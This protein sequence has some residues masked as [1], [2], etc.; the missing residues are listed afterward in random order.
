[1]GNLNPD[2]RHSDL[3]CWVEGNKCSHFVV[4]FTGKTQNI[5]F[6][7]IRSMGKGC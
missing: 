3:L 2:E 6:R 1:M 5:L 7:K 4:I